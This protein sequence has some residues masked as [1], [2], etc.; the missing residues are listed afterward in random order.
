MKNCQL[1]TLFAEDGLPAGTIVVSCLAGSLVGAC[2]EP[3]DVGGGSQ[4]VLRP[5]PGG[6]GG[7]GRAQ[8][9]S[10]PL[11]VGVGRAAQ[12]E[13]GARDSVEVLALVQVHGLEQVV[14]GHSVLTARLCELVDVLH[15]LEGG[16]A[17][18]DALHAAGLQ[19]VDDP[20]EEL[21][22]AQLAVQVPLVGG[23]RGQPHHGKQPVESLLLGCGI[24]LVEHLC[25]DVRL[26]RSL[27]GGHGAL[28]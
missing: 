23:R 25:C 28:G 9:G 17:G 2:L 10:L 11:G 14:V 4:L 21:A 5:L 22:G 6:G 16:L 27:R 15:L 3:N 26:E 12:C 7:G 13:D 19:G 24:T 18:A 8:Q 20:A 1:N